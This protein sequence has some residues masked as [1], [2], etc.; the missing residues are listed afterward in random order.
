MQGTGEVR[1]GS[2]ELRLGLEFGLGVQWVSGCSP[3]LNS[4]WRHGD[5]A[6]GWFEGAEPLWS[7]EV[8]VAVVDEGDHVLTLAALED[9]G[10]G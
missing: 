2:E 9:L 10:G 4:L 8:L 7:E 6:E 5:D 1:R 3:A